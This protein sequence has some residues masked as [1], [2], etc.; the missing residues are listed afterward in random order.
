MLNL[1]LVATA[2]RCSMSARR[3]QGQ[4]DPPL[5]KRGR[6]ESL[7]APLLKKRKIDAV[8]AS[9]LQRATETA[10]IINAA[11]ERIIT[12]NSLLRELSFGEWEGLTYDEVQ[13]RRRR[14]IVGLDEGPA[15]RRSSWR[16][17]RQP[18]ERSRRQ[19][20]RR[21]NVSTHRS[22]HLASRSRRVVAG[23]SGDIVGAFPGGLLAVPFES[24]VAVGVERVR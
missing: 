19:L 4:V 3:F 18:I 5:N 22:D 2:R 16:R 11:G 13:Q 10:G 14:T 23:P 20:S 24:R 17:E 7:L 6:A 12:Q 8:Y 21:V 9:D 1:L 15:A